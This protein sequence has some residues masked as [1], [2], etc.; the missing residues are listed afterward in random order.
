MSRPKQQKKITVLIP[1]FNEALGIADVIKTFMQQK[2]S[3]R[4]FVL[5][6]V[7]ID[8]NSTD[9]T[10]A[11]ARASGATVLFESQ[12][13]KGNAIRKGFYSVSEDTDFVVML[14]GDD[15][16]RPEEML[17][18]IEL[19]DS[20]FC[21][22]A[23]GSRLSGRMSPGSMRTLNRVG[24]HLYTALVRIFYQIPVTD[25]LT[26]YFA[27]NHKALVRLR[28][29]LKSEGFAIE[30]EMITKM[31]KLGET[32]CSVPISYHARAG[33]SNLKPFQD[34]AKIMYMLFKNLFWQPS[35]TPD[36]S[37]VHDHTLSPVKI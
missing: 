36:I 4:G 3:G 13:G 9:N 21:S 12:K 23:I 24:N 14:D 17:R 27:W 28:P 31:A 10:A 6:I 34:G 15:T 19:L 22:V 20:G 37:P 8:N 11:V 35:L 2:L 25:V 18:L 33:D 26:G 29:H 7:V 32:I 5:D 16:Y 1:C 30:M